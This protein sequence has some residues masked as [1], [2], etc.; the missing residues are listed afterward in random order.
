[1][2]T[3]QRKLSW[4]KGNIEKEEKEAEEN[5]ISEKRKFILGEEGHI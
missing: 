1:M 3:L 4:E 5:H 2:L